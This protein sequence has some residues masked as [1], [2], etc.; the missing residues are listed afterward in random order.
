MEPGLAIEAIR[1][2]GI[3]NADRAAGASPRSHH[4]FLVFCDPRDGTVPVG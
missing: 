1:C 2:V 3:H 4:K